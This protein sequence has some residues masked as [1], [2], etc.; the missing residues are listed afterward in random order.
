MRKK[1]SATAVLAEKSPELLGH[2]EIGAAFDCLS[3]APHPDQSGLPQFLQMVRHGAWCD[4]ET[5]GKIAHAG[6]VS[7]FN[8]VLGRPAAIA[9]PEKNREPMG[10]PEHFEQPG[11][12]SHFQSCFAFRH[13]LKR[14]GSRIGVNR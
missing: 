6:R 11:G 9:Q 4:L 2:V 13:G 12:L 14:G 5:F 10:M 8:Q 1:N 3:I 7:V